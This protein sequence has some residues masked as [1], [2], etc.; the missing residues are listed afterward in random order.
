MLQLFN[1]RERSS[2]RS[3]F[4]RSCACIG[5]VVVVGLSGCATV[6]PNPGYDA[7]AE[8]IQAATGETEIYHPDKEAEA[9]KRVAD[10]LG[11]GLTLQEAGQVALLN[12]RTVQAEFFRI[13]VA[14]ADVVQSG[15]FANPSLS[16][17][18]GFPSGGGLVA[19][20][21]GIVQGIGDLWQM[22]LRK[23]V[24]KHVRD[25]VILDVAKNVNDT[26][27]AVKR[28]FFEL[29]AAERAVTIATENLT[30]TQ[31]L[32]D[33]TLSRQE[34]GAG[35]EVDVNAARSENMQSEAVLLRA[36]LRILEARA[37]LLM[38]LGLSSVGSDL[39]VSGDLPDATTGLATAESMLA[40]AQES[41][42]DLRAAKQAVM[43]AEVSVRREQR[44]FLRVVEPGV[45]FE[46]EQRKA[47]ESTDFTAGPTLDLELPIFDQN[48]AQIAR[49]RFLHSQAIKVLEGLSIS[50]QQQVRMAFQR[51]NAMRSLTELYEER[52]IP[53][54]ETSLELA[55]EAY[56]LGE[57]SF[58]FV[59]DAQ[60]TLLD[61]RSEY[62]NAQ[63]SSA[64]AIVDLER[65]TGRPID[66]VIRGPN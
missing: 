60:K 38:L 6:D 22:P 3:L 34:A 37:S 8:E 1:S 58:V 2:V 49:A 19:L 55:R 12:N 10:L 26:L 40:L 53:Q 33:L 21:G 43:A 52:L 30:V 35:N 5:L 13:G 61:S 29:V 51:A 47:G 36:N 28:R 23:R 15:L 4:E 66:V 11:D 32:L 46:R 27:L 65:A 50:V 48:Q 59:L 64:N 20:E 14:E 54:Q 42:L 44:L 56:R 57:A 9:E 39:R 16:M 31:E 25:R 62:L 41:R 7:A 18:I 17:L 24:S 45:S 63:H